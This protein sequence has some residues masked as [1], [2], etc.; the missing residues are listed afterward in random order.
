ML[1]IIT[2]HSSWRAH[3]AIIGLELEC[4]RSRWFSY[5]KLEAPMRDLRHYARILWGTAI[6]GI[7]RVRHRVYRAVR[8][9]GI[10]LE[11]H[12]NFTNSMRLSHFNTATNH[13][14][15]SQP[16]FLLPLPLL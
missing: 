3:I 8:S 4:I 11:G 10:Q 7:C 13:P 6:S 9:V 15:L 16:Y 1:L 2:Q 12:R 14:N 5:M